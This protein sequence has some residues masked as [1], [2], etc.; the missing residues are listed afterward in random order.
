[1]QCVASPPMHRGLASDFIA[2]TKQ[3]TT[4][5]MKHW[6]YAHALQQIL[7][8]DLGRRDDM[9][10]TAQHVCLNATTCPLTTSASGPET[11]PRTRMEASAKCITKS[12]QKEAQQ[13]G[14]V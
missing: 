11:R 13:L 14:S 10:I 5:H 4:A 6:K 2:A 1:M 9:H 8:L 7:Q 3:R 12:K